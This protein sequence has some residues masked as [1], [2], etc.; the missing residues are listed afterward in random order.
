MGIKAT[1]LNI[2]SATGPTPTIP[3]NKDRR[4]QFFQVS[5]T[6]PASTKVA[7][8]PA[9]AS[10]TTILMFGSVNSNA[11]T[12]ATITITISDN[13]GTISTGTVN[14]LTNGATTAAVQMTNLPNLESLP[15]VGDKIITVTYAET[16][17]ASTSGGPWTFEINFVR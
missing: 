11:G 13:T 4:A 5:R 1:D 12:T 8:L 17:T 10:I 2:L 7:V 6:T 14:V 16:G 3:G 15:L 9:D